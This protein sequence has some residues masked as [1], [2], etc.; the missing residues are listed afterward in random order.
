M[1]LIDPSQNGHA[2]E[3]PVVDTTGELAVTITLTA[4]P[5]RGF[6]LNVT[7][8][9]SLYADTV[10]EMCGA[11]ARRYGR[12]EE[13]ERTLSAAPLA[14]GE[15]ITLLLRA[16]LTSVGLMTWLEGEPEL[17]NETLAMIFERA[18]HFYE[19]QCLLMEM[20]QAQQKA[21]Q[22]VKLAS[23]IRRPGPMHG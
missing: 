13:R 14:E 11:L 4:Q 7:H 15:T 3:Q 17:L 9:P 18:A 22:A 5:G 2:E 12:L 1:S 6:L 19:R 23:S 21:M 10:V 8:A 20:A 16:R